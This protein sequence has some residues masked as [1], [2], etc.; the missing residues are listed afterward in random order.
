MYSESARLSTLEQLGIDRK[1]ET[2]F[3]DIT[4]LAATICDTPIS[5]ITM[6]EQDVQWTK[7][8][9]GLSLLET[10]RDNSFCSHAIVSPFE[11]MEVHNTLEDERFRNNP[12]VLEDPKMRFYAGMPIVTGDGYPLGAVCVIDGEPRSLSLDQKTS[13]S[14]LAR[15]TMQLIYARSV[16][17][18]IESIDC[19]LSDDLKG[20]LHYLP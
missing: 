1:P 11:L 14:T 6:I 7:S 15:V 4:R 2:V 17:R 12:L 5:L 20:M 13:L 9:Y 16:R 3:D 8:R 19:D 10:S 18:K